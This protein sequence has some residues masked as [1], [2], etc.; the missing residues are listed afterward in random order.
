[1]KY[2]KDTLL[3]P[4]KDSKIIVFCLVLFLSGLQ[5]FLPNFLNFLNF[6]FN[7]QL[8]T[9]IETGFELE[10][11]GQVDDIGKNALDSISASM[12]GSLSGP[13]IDNDVIQQDDYIIVL[14][15]IQDNSLI[16]L[17]GPET[18]ERGGVVHYRV[19]KGDTISTIAEIFGVSTNTVLWA[20]NLKAK[21]L[22]KP[23]DELAILPVSGLKHRVANKDTVDSIAKKYKADKAQIIAFNDISADGKLKINQELIIPGGK[24]PAPAP[25]VV[26]KA[27]QWSN[28]KGY[29]SIP[30]KGIITQGAHGSNKN[31]VD[32]GNSRGTA[33]YAAAGGTVQKAI[34][35][36]WNQGAGKYITIKHPNGTSTLYAHLDKILVRKGQVVQKGDNIGLMGSTGRSSGSH[37]HFDI[38]G[39]KNPLTGYRTRTV[40]K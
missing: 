22:I 30:A 10:A 23:G 19:E 9:G 17:V 5:F 33:I 36:G 2:S 32:I 27:G 18:F 28:I 26:A 29:F 8:E 1:M 25:V 12:I 20:N 39:A 31:A 7:Q 37:L 13:V 11:F 24:K 40:L 38:L 15:A 14:P 3:K 4:F 35:S 34:S 6:S 16:A 21:D